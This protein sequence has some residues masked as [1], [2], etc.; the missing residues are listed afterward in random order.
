MVPNPESLPPLE[1]MTIKQVM[2]PVSQLQPL[3]PNME[4]IPPEQM[5]YQQPHQQPRPIT[6]VIGG[7][8]F[9]FLQDSELDT[10]PEQIPSQTFTNQSFV[11]GPPPPIPMPPH[12]QTFSTNPIPQPGNGVEEHQEI[13]DETQKQRGRSRPNNQQF[14]SNNNGYNRP[15]QNRN[16]PRSGNRHNQ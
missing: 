11:T 15:R 7:G 14:Y 9:F 16:G 1:T 13:P 6:E 12:F 10:P 4:Q 8:S 2:Q 5:F 3:E